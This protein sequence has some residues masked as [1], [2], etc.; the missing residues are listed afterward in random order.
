MRDVLERRS[1][2]PV[3]TTTITAA[4]AAVPVV[5]VMLPTQLVVM[6]GGLH[7]SS[8]VALRGMLAGAWPGL[9]EWRPGLPPNLLVELALA[10]TSGVVDGDVVVRA[11][12]VLALVGFAAG[13]IALVRAAGAP[14]WTVL[15]L[16]PVQMSASLRRSGLRVF[17]HPN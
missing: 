1:A 5:V 16:L 6:D 9:L 4:V 17:D 14:T 15:L 11:T 2:G 13:A 10:A 8:S 12:V 3:T 7:L